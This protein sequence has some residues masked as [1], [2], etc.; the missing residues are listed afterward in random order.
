MEKEMQ[1][2]NRQIKMAW[3]RGWDFGLF[4]GIVGTVLLFTITGVII[5]FLY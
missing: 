1:E 2:V 3:E 4:C 5:K